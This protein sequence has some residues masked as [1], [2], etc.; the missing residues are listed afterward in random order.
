MDEWRAVECFPGYTVHSSGQVKGPTGI[1]LSGSTREYCRVN[2]YRDKCQFT[3][4]VHRLVAQ[5]FIPNPDGLPEVDHINQNKLDNR[6][7]NLRWADKSV[8]MINRP[9]KSTSPHRN[10]QV[11]KDGY[12]SVRLYRKGNFKSKTVKTL[13]EAI[14]ARDELL[15]QLTLV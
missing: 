13:E 15:R 2:L 5:A 3:K 14:A 9:Y 6:V 1:I 4:T 8:Q 12:F 11:R 10:I 7:E